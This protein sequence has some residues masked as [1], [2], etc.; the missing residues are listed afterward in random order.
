MMI[1]TIEWR[2]IGV[3]VVYLVHADKVAPTTILAFGFSLPQI[4]LPYH[5]SSMLKKFGFE[6]IPKSKISLPPG[7]YQH[8]LI[9]Y[10]SEILKLQ[11]C[12]ILGIGKGNVQLDLTSGVPPIFLGAASCPQTGKKTF[13]LK[14]KKKNE[15]SN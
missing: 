3:W 10:S 2:D 5:S 14:Q 8:E 7:L 13:Q 11:I 9:K 15:R 1:H 4:F 6:K 12:S